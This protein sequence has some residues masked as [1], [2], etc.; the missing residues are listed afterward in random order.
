MQLIKSI[1]KSYKLIFKRIQQEKK[2]YKTCHERAKALG[3]RRDPQVLMLC[4]GEL[5]PV[6]WKYLGMA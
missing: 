4:L 2:C 5:V 3:K 6:L 1:Y